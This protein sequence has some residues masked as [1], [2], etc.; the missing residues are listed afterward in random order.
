MTVTTV[1]LSEFVYC[2]LFTVCLFT[3]NLPLKKLF[4]DA[5]LLTK[6]KV[7]H[8]TVRNRSIRDEKYVTLLP[9]I[10]RASCRE[11]V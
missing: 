9:E 5:I 3:T 1:L 7:D 4:I 8:N 2:L 11:R 6:L 10:G